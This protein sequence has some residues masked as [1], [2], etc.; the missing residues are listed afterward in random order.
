MIVVDINQCVIFLLKPEYKFNK[1]V[2]TIIDK[3]KWK[4]SVN[5]SKKNSCKGSGPDYY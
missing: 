2:H 3:R 5:D 1:Q 4:N